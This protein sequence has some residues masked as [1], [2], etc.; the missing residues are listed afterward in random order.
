[1]KIKACIFFVMLLASLLLSGSFYSLIG[2]ICATIHE[3]GH[4]ICAK[5][6]GVKFSELKLTPF[7]ASLIP[8]SNLGSYRNE[9]LI[10]SAGPISNIVSACAASAFNYD[11]N[12]FLGFFITASIFLAVLNLLPVADFDGGRIIKALLMKKLPTYKA[13]LFLRITSFALIF[14]LWTFSL[15]LLLRIGSSIM[16]FVFSC[17]LFAKFFIHLK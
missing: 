13:D 5:I 16:L 12:N 17:S 1:M 2:V 6:L 8:I 15:Y 11:K 10:C 4:I 3:F 14:S 7:G 9:I